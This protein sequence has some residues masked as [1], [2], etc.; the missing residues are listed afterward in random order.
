MIA[1]SA[2][3]NQLAFDSGDP[4]NSDPR[5]GFTNSA[6]LDGWDPG[7]NGGYGFGPWSDGNYGNPV[8]IDTLPQSDNDL[9]APAFRLGAGGDQYYVS[10]Q[11]ANGLQPGQSFRI[12]LD[13][14]TIPSTVPFSDYEY[15]IGFSSAAGERLTLYSYDYYFDPD[16]VPGGTNGPMPQAPLFG[17][18]HFGIGATTANNNLN[19]GASLPPSSDS[20]CLGSNFCSTYSAVDGSDGFTL[21]VDILTADTYRMRIM[22]DNVPKLD[23]TG[24]MRVGAS[25]GQPLTSFFFWGNESSNEIH[26]GY[27]NNIELLDTPVEGIAGDY[28]NDHVVDARDYVLW[29]KVNGT[30][31]VLPNDP[32]PVPVDGD[33][34]NTWRETYGRSSAGSGGS[35]GV[36]EPSSFGMF[37]LAC[38]FV[39]R[40]RRAR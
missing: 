2:A 8:D 3:A 35:G 29:R 36:P 23:I 22:D 33:Q 24:Q 28:N 1:A 6:Y 5:P 21:T 16:Y 4:S 37:V 40:Q 13:A 10:R 25:A 11:F 9:G 27:F 34:Y 14:W 7:D 26:A 18:A 30:N 39:W 19:G 38:A 12:N 31:K 20:D 32:N 15:E 17:G